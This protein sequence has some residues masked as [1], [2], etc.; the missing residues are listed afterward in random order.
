MK[1]NNV[2]SIIKAGTVYAVTQYKQMYTGR[3]DNMNRLKE[4]I[5]AAAAAAVLI[6]AIIKGGLIAIGLIALLALIAIIKDV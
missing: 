6:V 2:R 3:R 4:P 1:I 5:K